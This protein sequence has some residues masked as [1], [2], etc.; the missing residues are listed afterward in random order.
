MTSH[1]SRKVIFAALA[2]NGLIAIT[3]FAAA[4]YTG[5][6]AM[7]SEAIHSL[8][9]TGNQGLLLH[10][11]KVA[12]KPADDRH[13]F[14]YGMELYFWAFVVAILIFG[15]G[16]GISIY[17]GVIKIFDPHPITSPIVNYVVLSFA[18]L[19]ESGS[20]A[21][22]FREFRAQKGQSTYIQTVRRSK[23]PTIFTV[24]FEDSAALLGLVIAM[25]GIALADGLQIPWLDGAA[26]VGIGAVLAITAAVLAYECKGL[27]IGESASPALISGVRDMALGTSGVEQINELRTMHMGPYDV[28][29]VLSLDVRDDMPAGAVERTI[30]DLDQSLKARFPELKRIFIEI[31]GN[32]QHRESLTMAVT[33][34]L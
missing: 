2:G 17:E 18:I 8:V 20:W 19:F 1:S 11:L 24:F 3:K 27:L 10:G 32:A 34:P 15:L 16:A 25:A 13:P 9:D 5:S 21:V 26:S 33:K 4:G 23:D 7:L 29:L 6:S 22:A 31:Q 30:G 12:R 28:L 14:G